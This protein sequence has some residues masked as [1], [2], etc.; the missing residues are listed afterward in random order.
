MDHFL[1]NLPFT[2][3]GALVDLVDSQSVSFSLL[4]LSHLI[5]LII[6]FQ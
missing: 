1:T 6:S 4:S 3:S 2:T 5:S